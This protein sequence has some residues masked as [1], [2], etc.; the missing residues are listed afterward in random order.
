M[1]VDIRIT[2]LISRLHNAGMSY[3]NILILVINHSSAED[4]ISI[5]EDKIDQLQDEEEQVD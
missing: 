5:L 4:V 2:K 3:Y 1:T